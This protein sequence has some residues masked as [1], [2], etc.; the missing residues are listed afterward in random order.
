MG[1]YSNFIQLRFLATHIKRVSCIEVVRKYPTV[2]CWAIISDI[3]EAP[4][5][6]KHV[7]CLLLL[8]FIVQASVR[9]YSL[10]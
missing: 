5:S 2:V 4:E 1:R 8:N 7:V 10:D 9:S 3:H 6:N